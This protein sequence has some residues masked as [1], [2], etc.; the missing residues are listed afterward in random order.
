M[1]WNPGAS[2]FG[3]RGE[4]TRLTDADIDTWSLAGALQF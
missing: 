2:R 4:Y 1:Q 3:L